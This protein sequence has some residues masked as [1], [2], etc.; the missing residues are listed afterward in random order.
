M[1]GAVLIFGENT[2]RETANGNRS[3]TGEKSRVADYDL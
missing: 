1:F 2:G 3:A